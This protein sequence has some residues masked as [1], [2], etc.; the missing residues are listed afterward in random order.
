MEK[1]GIGES[2][3]AAMEWPSMGLSIASSNRGDVASRVS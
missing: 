3:V 1:L 2:L